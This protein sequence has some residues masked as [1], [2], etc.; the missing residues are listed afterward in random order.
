MIKPRQRLSRPALGLI[1]AAFLAL[2]YA[3]AWWFISRAAQNPAADL[4][5]DGQVNV[6]DLSI[7]LTK[8]G[9]TVAHA[10]D[11]NNDGS[12]GIL[13][14]S[15]LLSSWGPVATATRDPLKQPFASNSIWNMP[16]GSGAVFV[17]AGLDGSP[18]DW[19][20]TP[21]PQIDEEYII[22]T[23]TAPMTTVKY[24]AVAWSGGDRCNYTSSTTL[25]TVPMPTNFLVPNGT[26]NNGAAILMADGRTIKQMQPFTRC[27]AGQPATSLL[28]FADVDLYGD[29]RSGAHGGSRL[30]SI[31]GSIRLGELRPGQQGMKHALKVNVYAPRDL[32]RCT[33]SADCF[34]WPALSHDS[35]AIG[36]YGTENNNLN[37]A[38]KMGS[39]LA[40]PASVDINS[41]GLES[42]PGRQIAWTLQN[43][44][45][46]IVDSTGGLGFALSA[47][48]SPDGDMHA[49]FKADY[50]YDFEQRVNSNTTWSRDMQRL[51]EALH[52]VNNNS[53]TSIGGGG[54]PRQPLAPAIAP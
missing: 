25:T 19:P 46:Y 48:L 35:G 34:R 43:Y 22:L 27:T 11:I 32:Y 5:S 9:Q 49:Q 44:G 40:I 13:D 8:W 16:I 10:A 42:E 21:M 6:F 17:D 23:P 4:N 7:L 28:T 37:T 39:L 24:N 31:G 2:G 1:V 33:T 18:D 38:M 41:M 36:E 20:W 12:I 53:A 54:T 3:G 47:E 45:A 52:V 26:D 29:G 15:V 14:L 50:G 51:V 30:S